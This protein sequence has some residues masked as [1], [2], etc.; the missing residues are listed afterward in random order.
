M[1]RG[2][3]DKL[4]DVR[5]RLGHNGTQEFGPLHEDRGLDVVERAIEKSKQ[6]QTQGWV[7]TAIDELYWVLPLASDYLPLHLQLAE[8]YVLNHREDDAVSKLEMVAE[9][10]LT[11]VDYWDYGLN[12]FPI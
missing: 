3:E 11:K 1:T 5:V 12:Y 4:D 6:Y 2:W 7:L 8:L 10:Y 9:V